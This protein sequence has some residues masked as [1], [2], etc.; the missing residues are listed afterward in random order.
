[1]FGIE[2][3]L[4]LKTF[5]LQGKNRAKLRQWINKSHRENIVCEEIKINAANYEQ[6]K[7]ISEIWLARKR[8]T[9]CGILTRPFI[10]TSELDVRIFIAK[11]NDK[12][13][14]FAGFDPMYQNGKIIGYYHNFD[15]MLPNIPNGT[16]SAILFYALHKFKSE[17]IR[18]ISLGLSPLYKLKNH[19]TQ[20]KFTIKALR[21]TFKYLNFIYPFQGNARHKK[22]F[23]GKIKPIYFSSNNNSIFDL[24]TILFSLGA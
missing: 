9:N 12:I 20:N 8:S 1:M 3:I 5:S 18:I 2:T 11:K 10:D 21:F 23:D 15:R 17:N 19:A 16:G 13:I 22:K 4:D 24:I 6:L 7:E 14:A